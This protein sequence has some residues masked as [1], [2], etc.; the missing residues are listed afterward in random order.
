M[1]KFL[2]KLS[3]F[4]VLLTVTDIALGG[5]FKLFDYTRSGEIYKI[6]SIM[7]KETPQLL[8]LGS[9][10]ASH[11]YNPE[12][13]KDILSLSVYNAGLDGVGTTIANGFF[14]GL[15]R[16]KYPKII[17]CELTPRFDLYQVGSIGLNKLYPY[18]NFTPIKD[19]ITSFDSSENYK[20]IF[21]G[22][23]LNSLLL[24]VLP[25]IFNK[26][27]D[28]NNGFTPLFGSIK[29][30]SPINLDAVYKKDP[31]KEM[32][33]RN[34]IDDALQHNCLLI[35]T[36]SPTFNNNYTSLYNDEIAIIQEYNLPLLNHLNDPR[37]QWKKDFFRDLTHMNI[38]GATLYSRIIANEVDSI[39][40]Q[41]SIN[42]SK[43]K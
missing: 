40:S 16:K 39:I 25:S 15:G 36:I 7:T 13:L 42:G 31:V 35:F 38:D 2:I 17:L 41:N 34:L 26:S 37:F 32:W 43:G 4:V 19:I 11:H 29:N 28:A 23:K 10:R 12:I 24:R 33:L 30:C 9:S 22:Y 21:N 6:H 8:V 5:V 3:I 18:S 27:D 1:K 14:K 20:L